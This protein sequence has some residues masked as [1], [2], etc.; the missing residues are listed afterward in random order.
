[1]RDRRGWR[2]ARSMLNIKPN[3]DRDH[4]YFDEKKIPEDVWLV[5]E[6][7]SLLGVAEFRLFEIAY[8]DWFGEDGDEKTIERYFTPYMFGEVVP[9]WVRHL[10]QRVIK[11]DREDALRP[12]DFGVYPKIATREDLRKGLDFAAWLVVSMVVLVLLGKA[13]GKALSDICMFPPCY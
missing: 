3:V 10:S 11:L 9:V 13:A 2:E 5:L 1:M 8:K 6:A 12:R 4:R 7:T